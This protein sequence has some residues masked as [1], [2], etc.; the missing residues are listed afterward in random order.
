MGLILLLLPLA[1]IIAP[2]EFLFESAVLVFG[3]LVDVI[4]DWTA[5]FG[6]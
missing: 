3:P 4:G 5:F 6:A 1:A 2:F